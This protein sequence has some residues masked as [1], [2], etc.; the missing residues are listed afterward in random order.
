M[1]ALQEMKA[2]TAKVNMNLKRAA[3]KA[4]ITATISS[5]TSR[6]ALASDADDETHDLGL[7]QRLLGHTSRSTT[8]KYTRGRDSKVVQAGAQQ[9]YARRPMPITEAGPEEDR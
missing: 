7:V 6:R 9:V 8:E 3:V 5:H 1:K 2:A 4:G